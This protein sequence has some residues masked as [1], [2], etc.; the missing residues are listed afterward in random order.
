MFDTVLRFK[1]GSALD[2]DTPGLA[3]LALYAL[4]QGTAEL[5]ATQFTERLEGLGAVMNRQ[6][7]QD[8]AIVTLRS[9]NT[10]DLRACAL[11]LITEMVARPALRPEDVAKISAR[12]VGAQQSSLQPLHARLFDATMEQLLAGHPYATPLAGTLD[13]LGS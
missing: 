2:G 6:V 7:T 10:P 3:A 9:L 8:C 11:R 5:N 13:G 4:D 1:A 12:L